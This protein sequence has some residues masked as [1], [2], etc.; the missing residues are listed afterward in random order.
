[1][2]AAA[3]TSSQ[4]VMQSRGILKVESQGPS[5]SD[6]AGFPDASMSEDHASHLHSPPLPPPFEDLAPT[7][8]E[9][10]TPIDTQQTGFLTS[11]TK[12]FKAMTAVLRPKPEP[13]VVPLCQA[14]A[15]G[16]NRQIQGLIGEGANIN[17]R[18]D[19]GNT[20]LI[21]SI[22]HHQVN[23]FQFLLAA[24]ADHRTKDSGTK[25]K[26]PFFH[27][28]DVASAEMVD[29]LIARGLD[30]NHRSITGESFFVQVVMDASPEGVMLLLTRG[31]DPNARDITGA[32][33]VVKA[34]AKK[35]FDVVK[36][37]L[38]Y[39]ADANSKDISGQSLVVMA[40]NKNQPNMV[41]LFLERGGSANST[42]LTGMS[43]LVEAIRKND[44]AVAKMLL[45]HGADANAKDLMGQEALVI[46]MRREQT[47]EKL[48]FA[49]MLLAH[50]AHPNI[51]DDWENS[52]LNLALQQND[53]TLMR[54][55]LQHG[56]SPNHTDGSGET[57]I[58]SAMDHGRWNHVQIL[59]EHGASPNDGG[60]TGRTPLMVAMQKG[61]SDMAQILL[62]AGANPNL[63]S[64][65]SPLEFARLAGDESLSRLLQE[66]GAVSATNAG[67]STLEQVHAAELN[68]HLHARGRPDSPPPAYEAIG[69]A[70]GK[71]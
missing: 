7:L 57:Q 58:V 49:T 30:V 29:I 51:A 27:A 37:L 59:L 26:S 28:I 46:V 16:N 15:R 2:V 42:T 54:L 22:L 33:V 35:R 43:I 55:L 24:G 8:A 61:R 9:G 36:V 25:R 52:P 67:P 63:G 48:D 69:S 60:K 13:L 44:V 39:G 70:S 53:T 71:S 32:P 40:V 6:S 20:A 64:S 56:G 45:A 65:V 34:L 12:S 47:A 68:Q 38:D 5:D 11:L 18:D 10:S 4:S 23:T 21:C 31:A 66:H 62:R 41:Q 1:M 17:G 14:A 3:S 50:G 19:D